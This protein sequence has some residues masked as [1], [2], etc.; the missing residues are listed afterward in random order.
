MKLI[1]TLGMYLCCRFSGGTTII[2]AGPVQDNDAAIEKMTVDWLI[3]R[4]DFTHGKDILF[5]LSLSDRGPEL[6]DPHQPWLIKCLERAG[7][8]TPEGGGS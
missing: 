8:L 7:H 4:M 3:N 5:L 1:D 6:S 2:V